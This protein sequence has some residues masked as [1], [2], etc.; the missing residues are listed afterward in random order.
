MDRARHNF[1][2]L[3]DQD[4]AKIKGWSGDKAENEN[5]QIAAVIALQ[6]QAKA[7][8][9]RGKCVGLTEAQRRSAKSAN[10]VLESIKVEEMMKAVLEIFG[11]NQH[12]LVRTDEETAEPSAKRRKTGEHQQL[13]NTETTLDINK[14]S[15]KLQAKIIKSIS[16]AMEDMADEQ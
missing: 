14:Y 13:A 8:F 12:M 5:M 16:R 3:A 15:Q 11:Y 6:L 7:V 4:T 9:L 10:N 2:A 1:L